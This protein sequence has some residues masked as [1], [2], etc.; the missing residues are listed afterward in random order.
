MPP[1]VDMNAACAALEMIRR[2]NVVVV[3]E[4][5]IDEYAFCDAIGKSGKEPMLVTRALHCETQ[6]GGALAIANHVASFCDD[7]QVVSALGEC[8]AREAFVR[9]GLAPNIK[10]SFVRK[11]G[12]PTIVK[13]R[14]I[15]AYTKTKLLGVYQMDST[16]MA[17]EDIKAFCAALDRAMSRASLVIV[18][19]YGH[20]LLTAPTIEPLCQRSP[21]LAVNTQLNAD[22]AGYNVL[23]K[24]S[25]AD[26]VCLHEGE[27]RLDARDPHG[28][29][30]ELMN[31]S[32]RRLGA[33][34][35]MV[36]R[37][38]RGTVLNTDLGD[39]ECS[40]LASNVVERIGAGDAVLAISSLAVAAGL[41]G[42][43]VSMFANL[44]GAQAVAQL[45]NHAAIQ[46]GAFVDQMKAYA[47]EQR[48]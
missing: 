18:A 30:R 24:Y 32:R 23:S 48:R 36:T 14:Y 12:S 9:S 41:E 11:H 47:G 45:G 3:G 13:R 2:L 33:K 26:Y 21:F 20:G 29:L 27:L 35:L 43:L 6:V 44:A 34:A 42:G 17:S 40:S 19:D 5:I 7:V 38:R 1:K 25:R 4:S 28:D 10:P 8:D 16:P 39:Y 15:D 22:N 37:G 31:R 46:K